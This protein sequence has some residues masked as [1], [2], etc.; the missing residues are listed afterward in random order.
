MI[1][2]I[3]KSK[4]IIIFPSKAII[5]TEKWSGKINTPIPDWRL[6]P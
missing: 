4:I 2:V 5:Q 6:H 3:N 1:K